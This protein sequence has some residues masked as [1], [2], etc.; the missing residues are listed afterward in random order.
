MQSGFLLIGINAFDI[1][2]PHNLVSIMRLEKETEL[3][4]TMLSVYRVIY[5][6]NTIPIWTNNLDE[7]IFKPIEKIIHTG[8]DISSMDYLIFI[9]TASFLSLPTDSCLMRIQNKFAI[10]NCIA[11]EMSM[12]KCVS[13]FKVLELLSIIMGNDRD[14]TALV[15]TGDVAFT[16]A[17]RVVPQSTLVGDAATA[18]VFSIDACNHRLL[19]VINETLLGFEKGIYLNAMALHSF[20]CLFIDKMVDVINKAIVKANITLS[21]VKM[22]LPHNVNMPTWHKIA[23]ALHF[24]IE[25]IYLDNIAKLGHCFCSDHLINLK[26]ALSDN[27]LAKGD[28]Y[29]MAGCGLGFYL[30]AAVLQY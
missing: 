29:V 3:P 15:V 14:K 19:S 16:P 6:L 22:I 23:A 1:F 17:L 21:S 18:C 2:I 30:S 11:F 20:D 28:F 10:R 25:K 27:R 9:H 4:K 7:L 5:G 12:Y 8:F 24:P 26:S 13:F